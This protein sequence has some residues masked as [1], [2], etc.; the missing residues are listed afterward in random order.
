MQ[1]VCHSSKVIESS[2]GMLYV[3]CAR[4][5]SLDEHNSG[6]APGQ[7]LDE[8]NRA[9]SKQDGDAVDYWIAAAATGAANRLRIKL[10]PR[11]AH[12]TDQRTQILVRE[13]LERCGKVRGHT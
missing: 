2:A 12:G 13:T 11:M 5:S 1:K 4:T 7:V 3:T 6:I 10:Q 8:L 9:F